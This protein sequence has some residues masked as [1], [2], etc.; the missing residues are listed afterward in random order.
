MSSG[1]MNRFLVVS[2]GV[3]V[4]VFAPTISPERASG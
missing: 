2:V 4:V 1:F 3:G